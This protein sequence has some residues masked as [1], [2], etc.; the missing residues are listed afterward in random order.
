M[1]DNQTT[2]NH[3]HFGTYSP[4]ALKNA[5]LGAFPE[6]TLMS[7]GDSWE[8]WGE[9]IPSDPRHIVV[10][11]LTNVQA[12]ELTAKVINWLD[13]MTLV[14]Q[15]GIIMVSTESG[16]WSEPFYTLKMRG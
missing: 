8:V 5:I 12:I 9:D 13:P 15:D 2:E 6:A 14:N 1:P 7:D 4:A 3:I 11:G 10:T 16:D